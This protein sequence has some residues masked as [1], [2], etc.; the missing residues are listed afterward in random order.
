MEHESINN[1]ERYEEDLRIVL[2]D[3]HNL[4]GEIRSYHDERRKVA[5]SAVERALDEANEIIGQMEI[6]VL[7]IPLSSRLQKKTKIQNKIAEINRIRKEFES[8]YRYEQYTEP[9]TLNEDLESLDQRNR[10][11]SGTRKLEESSERLKNAQRV[12]DETKEIGA[13]ILRDLGYQREQIVMTKNTLVEAD[14]Y[15]DKSMRTLK[16]MARRVTTNKLITYLIIFVL[17]FLIFAIIWNKL[18]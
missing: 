7:Q 5:I 10:L 12:A 9:F 3:I 15:V 17:V 6:E 4:I 18:I 2:S 13:N 11:L 16:T 14:S 1:F 8:F